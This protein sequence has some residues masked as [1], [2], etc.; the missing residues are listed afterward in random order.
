M[1]GAAVNLKR[2]LI[3][4]ETAAAEMFQTEIS[5]KSPWPLDRE[6][7]FR[8]II[9][10]MAGNKTETDNDSTATTKDNNANAAKAD[11]EE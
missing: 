7:V 11:K 6:G 2:L 10:D 9:N 4:I 3:Q 5:K 1:R 8:K